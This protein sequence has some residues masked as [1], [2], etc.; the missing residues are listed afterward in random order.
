M[1]KLSVK[2]FYKWQK[3]KKISDTSL[4]KAIQDFNNDLASV[5]L[6]SG[7]HKLRIARVG[8]GKSSGFRTILAH[9]K[10]DRIIFLHGFAKS[11]Q[12][13]ISKKELEMFKELANTLF[14]LSDNQINSALESGALKEILGV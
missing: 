14:M 2:P 1:W 5:D 11:D 8:Q 6:G 10:E 12:E 4:M 13:N 3:S 7:L 9:K